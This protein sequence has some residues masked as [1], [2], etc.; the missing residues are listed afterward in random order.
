MQEPSI[1]I[2]LR[3]PCFVFLLAIVSSGWPITVMFAYRYQ[4]LH[5]FI[6]LALPKSPILNTKPLVQDLLQIQPSG[7]GPTG[8][9]LHSGM[10]MSQHFPRARYYVESMAK[11]LALAVGKFEP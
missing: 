4:L 3:V 7:S 8:R 10:P 9:D 1:T 5:S 6:F 11:L 2:L